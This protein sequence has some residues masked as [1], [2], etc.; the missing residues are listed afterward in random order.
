MVMVALPALCHKFDHR[1]DDDISL[2]VQS[3][4]VGLEFFPM[5]IE[6]DLAFQNS[7]VG[8]E[9]FPVDLEASSKHVFCR[10]CR[11]VSYIGYANPLVVLQPTVVNHV[12][13]HAPDC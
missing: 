12:S 7:L 9:L 8:T 1:P 3:S 13:A 11:R 2:G 6:I 10:S 5:E 4:L